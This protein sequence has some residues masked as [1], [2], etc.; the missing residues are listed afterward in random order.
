MGNRF[1]VAAE[2]RPNIVFLMADDLGYGDIG[3]FGQT[4]IRTPNLDQLAK[5]GMRFTQCYAGNAVCA[6]S[7]CVLMTGMHPG[8]ASGRETIAKFS[9][10]ASTDSRRST[11]TLPRL[12]QSLGYT[13]GGFG[14]WG[15][16]GPVSDG[17]PSKQGFNRWFGYN[18]QRVAHSHY[19]AISVGQRRASFPLNNPPLTGHEKLPADADPNDPASYAAFGGRNMAWTV[20]TEQAVKFVKDNK[21]RPFFLYYPTIIPH[22]ALQVPADSLAEYDGKFPETPYMGDYTATAARRGPPLQQWSRAWT[23][24]W[25]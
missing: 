21:D 5:E 13:T 25:A 20:I 9:R 16:G 12:L 24:T 23:V 18:C 10:K 19:P 11:V 4:K 22:L 15:L 2:S 6:P 17:R 8:H 1:A 14:K 7:R 3:P